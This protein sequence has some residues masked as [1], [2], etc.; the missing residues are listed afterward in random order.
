MLE[1]PSDLS[2]NPLSAP[3]KRYAPPNQRSRG[4]SRRKSGDRSERTSNLH[5][6]DGDK[7]LGTGLGIDHSDTGSSKSVYESFRPRL[8]ALN[9]CCRS[10]ASQLL[11]E[12][13][14][15]A[16]HCYSDPTV[17]LSE[18]PVMYTGSA[19]SAWG[20]FRLPHQLM[21][22]PQMDFLAELRQAINNSNAS[23]MN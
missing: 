22:A 1:N 10:E 20:N 13:W 7:N 12:R 4:L 11:H 23:S 19:A 17:D 9:G 2:S 14:N 21:S 8:T 3:I 16:V 18:R 5:L 6:V 15:G